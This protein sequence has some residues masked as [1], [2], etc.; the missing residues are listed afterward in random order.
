MVFCL[1]SSEPIGG[2]Q[3]TGKKNRMMQFSGFQKQ[4]Q[5]GMK[6][7]L[8]KEPACCCF[9]FLCPCP[10]ACMARM[11]VLKTRYPGQDAMQHYACC[12]GI[13][14]GACCG[15][16]G[17][18]VAPFRD[19]PLVGLALE[20]LCCHGLAVSST[21]IFVM[22]EW[23]L[24]T[25]PMDYQIIRFSNCMQGLACI[26]EV[27]AC[28]DDSFKEAAQ[29]IQCLADLVYYATTGCMHAQTMAEM[30]YQGPWG[31]NM[32]IGS[33]GIPVK[34]LAL[35]SPQPEPQPA[36]VVVP[37]ATTVPLPGAPVAA[38]TANAMPNPTTS[39]TVVKTL[40]GQLPAVEMER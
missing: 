15:L 5:V 39:A 37:V 34:S 12:Q 19:C 36:Q 20:S 33:V 9:G 16:V 30:N 26:C 14:D 17:Y 11:K 1:F 29:I 32:A 28:I 40:P 7:T 23:Q 31:N 25:D 27:L 13:F 21:R 3:A 24:A 35:Q 22:L 6:D 2:K 4:F 18:C 8:C 38:A 10:S